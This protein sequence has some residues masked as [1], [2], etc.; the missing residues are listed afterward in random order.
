MIR[1]I[2]TVIALLA[3]PAAAQTERA[4]ISANR[5]I[6]S[7]A[8]EQKNLAALRA[9]LDTAEAK[10][11]ESINAGVASIKN[12]GAA[13]KALEKLFPAGV[14][15]G[16]I[17]TAPA[18]VPVPARPAVVNPGPVLAVAP[19]AAQSVTLASFAYGKPANG[20][21]WFGASLGDGKHSGSGW[22]K[23]GD[24]Q[25]MVDLG[26]KTVRLPIDPKYCVNAD[27][28]INE[29]VVKT[30]ATAIK[31]NITHGVSTVLDAH[32]YLLFTDPAVAT[33]WA[34]F[35]PA[36]EKAIDG[37]TPLFGIELA[38]EPGKGNKDLTVWTE[39]LRKTIR[40]IRTAGYQGYIF[41]GAG[42]WNNMTF[43]QLALTEVE[44][45][46]GVKAMDPY[47]RTI[48]TGH[49]YWNKDGNPGKTRNDQ[50]AAV[51]GTIVIANRY[52]PTLAVARR[53]GAK[54]VMSEIGGGIAPSG[55]LPAYNGA[56]KDGAALT[57]E[58]LSFAKANVDVLIGTWFWMA[59]KVKADYRHKVEAGNPH[60]KALQ[61]F[62]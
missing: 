17:V 4:V 28:T 37:P 5:P 6:A 38:N 56:G 14:P 31:F 55:P 48:Y 15:S 46:G 60:T 36:M 47:N 53:I 39:P 12:V 8:T 32:T 29:W 21:A 42:D 52:G 16:P 11:Q 1:T 57:A 49:D 2:L 58:Y 23:V 54:V 35:A 3:T 19:S 20:V 33:F 26:V 50:G 44:R 59:G 51:D 43:L 40:A 30:L 61:K 62:W 13:K 45:T 24:M 7:S 41:A 25:S 18:P 10:A 9:A 22:P 27:G 34:R